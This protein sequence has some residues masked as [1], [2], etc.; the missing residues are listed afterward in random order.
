M[1]LCVC[2]CASGP[3]GVLSS[4]RCYLI[5]NQFSQSP[6]KS[7]R[8]HADKTSSGLAVYQD[9]CRRFHFRLWLLWLILWLQVEAWSDYVTMDKKAADLESGGQSGY[10]YPQPASNP[11][12]NT[13]NY[14]SA[15]TQPTAPP[16][17]GFGTINESNMPISQ[18]TNPPP[19][20]YAQ[21]PNPG[22]TSGYAPPPGY[23]TTQPQGYN[24]TQPAGY[25]TTNY[26]FPPNNPSP[27]RVGIW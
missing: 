4:A 6:F 13:S 1:C 27:P 5:Y 18:T 14:V 12:Y 24:P 2:V 16:P 8:A 19:Y 9:K 26:G 3:R 17:V 11:A 23:T 7:T 15:F 22:A 21:N 25:N 10:S 20:G